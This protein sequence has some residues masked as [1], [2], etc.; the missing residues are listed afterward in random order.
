MQPVVA[1]G[2]RAPVRDVWAVVANG[3]MYSGWVVGASRIR[4]VDRAFPAPGSNLHQSVGL[5]PV[6][7]DDVTTVVDSREPTL[8]VLQVRSRPFG[9]ARVRLQL[10]QVTASITK[11]E[12]DEEVT[13]GPGKWLPR[14]LQAP[15]M[16]WRNREC[17]DRLARLAEGDATAA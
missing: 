8:L 9:E 1:R 16:N 12:V 5:W 2:I 4:G 6:V 14:R 7:I 3:W 13:R 10:A 11:V 15:I 17:L